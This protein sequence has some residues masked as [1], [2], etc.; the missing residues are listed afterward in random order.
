MG[1]FWIG[2]SSGDKKVGDSK[3]SMTQ[4]T[5]TKVNVKP[6]VQVDLGKNDLLVPQDYVGNSRGIVHPVRHHLDENTYDSLQDMQGI[7][8]DTLLNTCKNVGSD[9]CNAKDR[10]RISVNADTGK[11][12]VKTAQN[13]YIM[14]L[15]V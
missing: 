10:V 6:N 1:N 4:D 13:Q 8:K 15:W 12:S 2:T 3:S 7:S 14:S 9:S 11:V 5:C